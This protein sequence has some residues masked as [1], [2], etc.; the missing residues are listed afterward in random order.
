MLGLIAFVLQGQYM[1]LVHDHLAGMADAPRMLF[2]SSHI[3]LL[4]A[5]VLNIVMG[6]YLRSNIPFLIAE[7][8]VV[9]SFIVIVAPIALIAGFFTEPFL[10]DFLRPYTRPALYA[11]FG[12][13]VTLSLVGLFG[14]RVVDETSASKDANED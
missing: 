2:R 6:I 14:W 5:A 8:Q 13:G 11:L 9:I 12:V 7:L 1:D 4:L 3:Y 10:A